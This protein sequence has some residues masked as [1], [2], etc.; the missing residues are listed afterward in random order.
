MSQFWRILGKTTFLENGKFKEKCHA[1]GQYVF[2][3]RISASGGEVG[4]QG[5]DS[6][7]CRPEKSMEVSAEGKVAEGRIS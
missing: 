5:S 6:K 1:S 4:H 7:G 3:V 2:T